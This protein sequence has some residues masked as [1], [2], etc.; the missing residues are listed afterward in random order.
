MVL[1]QKAKAGHNVLQK[2][3]TEAGQA[4]KYTRVVKV[5]EGTGG[6]VRLADEEYK[7]LGESRFRMST[8]PIP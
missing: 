6:K 5:D 3:E 4:Y 2:D 8:R 1:V 7:V